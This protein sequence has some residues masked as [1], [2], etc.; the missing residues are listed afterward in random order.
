MWFSFFRKISNDGFKSVKNLKAFNIMIYLN[1]LK[2]TI[3]IYHNFKYSK[4]D[5]FIII[6]K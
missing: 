2:Q 6:I 1:K 4:F 3:Q 5:V